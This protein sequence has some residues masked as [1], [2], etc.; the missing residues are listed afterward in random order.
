M[1]WMGDQTS[2]RAS[3][4]VSDKTT[5][6]RPIQ[7]GQATTPRSRRVW[8]YLKVAAQ[9]AIAV[10]EKPNGI[11]RCNPVIPQQVKGTRR[12]TA[13]RPISTPMKA[14][15]AETI[16]QASPLSTTTARPRFSREPDMVAP[17]IVELTW[18]LSAPSEKP[19]K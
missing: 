8:G 13:V 16:P 14:R 5:A 15:T 11:R 4:E 9:V 18:T 7:P 12:A 19:P 3:E 1:S 6:Q 10:A 17:T 2:Q